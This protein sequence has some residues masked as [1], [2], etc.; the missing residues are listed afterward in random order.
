MDDKIGRRSRFIQ[1][2]MD[3]GKGVVGF[4]LSGDPDYESGVKKHLLRQQNELLERSNEQA[5]EVARENQRREASINADNWLS[6]FAEHEQR[7]APLTDEQHV[8]RMSTEDIVNEH[9]VIT[10]MQSSLYAAKRDFGDRDAFKGVGDLTYRAER[11]LTR[12]LTG[13]RTRAY[14]AEAGMADRQADA[15]AASDALGILSRVNGVVYSYLS[16]ESLYR[17]LQSA[18]TKR[19]AAMTEHADKAIGRLL[20]LKVNNKAT[21][22]AVTQLLGGSIESLI[23]EVERAPR[24]TRLVYEQVGARAKRRLLAWVCMLTGNVVI[25]FLLPFSLP[26][27]AYVVVWGAF[28]I[29][30][31]VDKCRAGQ[32]T[33]AELRRHWAKVARYGQGAYDGYKRI[34]R[35]KS[36]EAGLQ[37][38][39]IPDL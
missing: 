21:S 7:Y 12:E 14:A 6:G 19:T 5:K 2:D 36:L 35:A 24:L 22:E 28:L 4:F 27:L 30:Q 26:V 9:A 20:M 23:K 31:F 25:G 29:W 39:S 33:M 10:R 18:G 11:V 34:A 38:I 37:E 32:Q 17:I 3:G 1:G 8:R 15:L 16:S 13:R